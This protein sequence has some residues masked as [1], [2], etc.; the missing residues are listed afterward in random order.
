MEKQDFL[1]LIEK[2]LAGKATLE[3]ERMLINFYGSFQ[4][5]VDWNE[6]VLGARWDLEDKMLARLQQS[7]I[8]VQKQAPT[9]RL[10]PRFAAVAAIIV[11]LSAVIYFLNTSPNQGKHDTAGILLKG[12]IVPGENRAILTLA[13]GKT[14]ALSD[15]K[16][17]IV[18]NAKRLTYDD[19]TAVNALENEALKTQ[20]IGTPRGGTYQITLSDG[21]KVWLNAASSLKFP[22]S[23]ANSTER[24][25]EL[26]GEGYFEVAKDKKHPFMVK[27]NGQE[28]EVLGTRF[29]INAYTDEP[30]HKTTLLEGSIS[31]AN[32]SIDRSRLLVPNQQAIISGS[33]LQVK[34][35][36]AQTAVDWKNGDFIFK[37]E[38]LE[39]IMRKVARWYDVEVVYESNAPENVMLGGL[40]SRSKN[41]SAV[42]DL[43]ESTGKVHF[44]IRGKKIIVTK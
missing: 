32:L 18:I 41:I 27:S 2:Y 15:A 14:I 34:T 6:E 31:I 35:I 40:I 20:T 12:D 33:S 37:E 38:R 28:V 11:V 25:V 13:N 30:E 16:T 42:L 19:G 43:I 9:I 29:N 10:W 5:M 1:L 8:P 7:L 36:D 44:K 3:E 4:D 24:I 22:V 17:G 39:S 21:T 23:F 26:N